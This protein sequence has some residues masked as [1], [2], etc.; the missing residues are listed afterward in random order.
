[1]AKATTK[2]PAPH[3]GASR[4]SKASSRR[5]VPG[6]LW[7]LL[8]LAVGIFVAFLWHL[9]E[10]RKESSAKTPVAVVAAAGKKS[11]DIANAPAST[12]SGKGE[13][14]RF[15]FYTL[16][17]NQQAMSNKPAASKPQEPATTT[18]MIPDSTAKAAGAASS[19]KEPAYFLQ[20][21]SFKSEAEAD[22]RRASI[23]LLGL[24]VKIL[25]VPAKPGETWYRVVVGPI[26]GKD[27]LQS[28]RTSLRSNGVETMVMK[29]G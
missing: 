10:L 23:L 17:P 20:A 14:P 1:M 5:G 18:P 15:D 2:K 12:A 22:K 11:G 27:S 21:G 7:L 19:I 4:N 6:W 28:A 16:L 13:E 3:K 25:K 24:P 8:G 26:R 29:H 9:W